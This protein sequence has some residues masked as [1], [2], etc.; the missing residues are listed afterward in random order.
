MNKL[1][2]PNG[3]M[4]LFNDDLRFMQNA[5][6]EAIKAIVGMLSEISPGFILMGCEVTEGPTTFSVSEGYVCIDGEVLHA[7]ARTNIPNALKHTMVYSLNVYNDPAGNDQFEDGVLRD[8]YEI[9]EAL[10]SS[11][12]TGTVVGLEGVNSQYSRAKS[13]LTQLVPR[14]ERDGVAMSAPL[15]AGW[16]LVDFSGTDEDLLIIKQFGKVTMRAGMIPGSFGGATVFTLSQGFRPKAVVTAILPHGN[17]GI[18]RI[19]IQENGEVGFFQIASP[20]SGN[21]VHLDSI[22]FT[23]E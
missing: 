5:S 3:G 1:L 16:S 13:I 9:R 19:R 14:S 8:K 6:F 15:G 18:C 17:N 21:T 20:T 23:T 2:T 22:S 12:G 4:P 10:L 11:G 7:P